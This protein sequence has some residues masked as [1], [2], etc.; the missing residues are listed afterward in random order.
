MNTTDSLQFHKRKFRGISGN[1][2]KLIAFFFMLCDD[3]GYIFIENGV[4]YGQNA[5]YWN[6][7][8]NTPAG[9]KWLA[10]ADLLRHVGRLSF[11]IFAYFIC[12][13]FLHTKSV[14]KYMLRMAVFA[15]LSEVPFDLACFG[16][17]YYPEYQNVLFTYFI[18]LVALY[19]MD[20]ARKLSVILQIL[21]AAVF[22]YMAYLAKSDYG[23]VGVGLIC[24]LYL[25]RETKNAKLIVG[26]L[27]SAV[28]SMDYLCVSAL[29]FIGLKFYDGTRGRIPMKYF[30][31]AA[32]P[33]HYLIF[34]A[35]LRLTNG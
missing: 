23:A 15:I 28:E 26:A 6:M 12:E 16:T 25:L 7:A 13:G 21:I 8:I 3:I 1:L 4:L 18:A 20:Q 11:P 24:A 5:M 34:Y 33:L 30:Y 2:L 27:I 29:S 14:P 19:L 9:Q 17:P 32:Y 10:V 22:A 35:A 31:Y